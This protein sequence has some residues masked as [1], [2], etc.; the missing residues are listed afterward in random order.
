MTASR[1]EIIQVGGVDVTPAM[2]ETYKRTAR[3]GAAQHRR[4]LVARRTQAM[5]VA[6][7]AADVLRTDFGATQVVLIGSLTGAT[8][9]HER[10]DVDLVAWGLRQ[11]D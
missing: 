5:A 9:F 4:R 8:P 3:A 11:E 7:Q 1:H 6:Q 2:M 10:S